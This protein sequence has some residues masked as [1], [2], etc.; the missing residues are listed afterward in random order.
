MK[1]DS[2]SLHDVWTIFLLLGILL[3]IA[4]RLLVTNWTIHL[5]QVVFV[6]LIAFA[7]GLVVGFSRHRTFM[8]VFYASSYGLVVIGWLLA[9]IDSTSLIFRE[10][11]S[12]VS[13]RLSDAFGLFMNDQEIYDPILFILFLLVVFWILSYSSS[14]HLVRRGSIWV[15][16][17]PAGTAIL[18][19][20]HYDLSNKSGGLFIAI[21][22]FLVLLF[23]GRITFLRRRIDWNKSS[24]H[25]PAEAAGDI[26]RIVIMTGMVLLFFAWLLPV[27]AKQD[28]SLSPAWRS[29][30]SSWI[31]IRERFSGAL[32]GIQSGEKGEIVLYADE[33]KLGT[34]TRGGENVLFVVEPTVR[35]VEVI[36]NYWYV[37]N[38]DRYQDGSWTSTLDTRVDVNSGS[39][40]PVYPEWES[41]TF[42]RFVITTSIP[43]QGSL[44]APQYTYW[45]RRYTQVFTGDAIEPSRDVGYI[46]TV[47]PLQI[48]EGYEVRAWL[49]APTQKILRESSTDYPQ[50]I[51]SRYLALPS[52]MDPRIADLA[53]EI[54]ADANIPFDTALE[55]TQYLRGNMTYE[56]ELIT[57]PKD[58]DP[59]AWFL[60]DYKTGFCNYYATAEVLLL[61][62]L[63]IPARMAVGYAEGKYLIDKGYY[64]VRGEDSHAWPEVYFTGW[65]WVPFEPTVSQPDI[66]LPTGEETIQSEND[67][68]VTEPITPGVSRFAAPKE[69]LEGDMG[70]GEAF[71]PLENRLDWKYLAA[72]LLGCLG[73][74]ALLWFIILPRIRFDRFISWLQKWL[75]KIGAPV[76]RQLERWRHYLAMTPIERSYLTLDWAFSVL[77]QEQNTAETPAEKLRRFIKVFPAA[78]H[79][80]TDLVE[81]FQNHQFSPRKADTRR[82]NRLGWKIRWMIIKKQIRILLG[83]ELKDF[84][85]R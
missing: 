18:I 64:E 77:H 84:T 4:A 1:K 14:F 38:Y 30:E 43:K 33:L 31:R 80:A 32:E 44:I 41:R 56:K 53:R 8:Q 49:N 42:S 72:I 61:R 76:P 2:S 36:R 17:L 73:I 67:P 11:L 57:P 21:Y 7:L 78:T 52:D 69:F 68:L 63:G 40:L 20:N 82:A 39:Y 45:V 48:G 22:L 71:V 51:R 28:R 29:I 10:R 55:V 12:S 75:E 81:E 5:A 6:I 27:V 26:S 24:I 9:A 85:Y 54:K 13:Q 23:I 79:A 16:I 58:I 3:T 66:V 19:I 35:R 70:N 62:S 83:L 37:R 50:W 60:F 34:Q 46:R 47:P 74:L 65:G 15:S 25:L 59:V